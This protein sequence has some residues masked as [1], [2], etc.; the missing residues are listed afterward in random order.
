M[1]DGGGLAGARLDV[2]ERVV[3][4]LLWR[5]KIL[6]LDALVLSHPD[7]DHY[8]GLAFL[9]AA[10]APRA[11][12]GTAGRAD[13]A[14]FAALRAALRRG[15][16]RARGNHRSAPSSSI[17]GVAV[18]VLPSR[19]HAHRGRDND[20]S[21][22]VQLRYGPTTVLLPGDLETGGRGRARRRAGATRCAA[23][24]SRCRTTAAPPRVRPPCLDAVAPRLAVVSAGADNRFGF[25]AAAV[26]A[27]Y[28]ARGVG[29]VAHRSR[30]RRAR[31]HRR[32]GVLTVRS[33]RGRALRIAPDARR[34]TV[35]KAEA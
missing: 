33:G 8:G 13:G 3:A 19:R 18:R 10:F 25:P 11:C 23:P 2:G 35:R 16:R 12:G 7:F 29:A 15:R 21:L 17:D 20:R 22:T 30:R 27:A 28:A 5:R 34:L 31:H 24:C 1:V 14:R 4:P 26:D 32:R 6:R 9:A